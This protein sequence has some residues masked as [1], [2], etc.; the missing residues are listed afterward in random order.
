MNQWTGRD[1]VFID[2]PIVPDF[3]LEKYPI[4]A[5]ASMRN[6]CL[7]HKSSSA[8]VTVL[9]RL[10]FTLSSSNTIASDISDMF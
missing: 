9:F 2:L 4:C 8:K 10:T 6:L 3:C 1:K 7:A 5:P